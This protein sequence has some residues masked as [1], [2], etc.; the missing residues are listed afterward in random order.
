MQKCIDVM[1]FL[2]NMLKICLVC[3]QNVKNINDSDKIKLF[4]VDSIAFF[5]F[6]FNKYKQVVNVE[7]N[8][9]SIF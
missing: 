5:Y 4:L 9:L 6:V 7:S 2:E 1:K 3:I 8:I